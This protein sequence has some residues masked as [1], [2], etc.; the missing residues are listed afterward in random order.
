MDILNG[1][2]VELK[3]PHCGI[4][5]TIPLDKKK[6]ALKVAERRTRYVY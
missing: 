2:E 1:G 3:C 5:V 4:F 6:K